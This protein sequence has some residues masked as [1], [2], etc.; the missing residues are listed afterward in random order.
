MQ[1]KKNTFNENAKHTSDNSGDHWCYQDTFE[2]NDHPAPKVEKIEPDYADSDSCASHNFSSHV[3]F[4]LQKDPAVFSTRCRQITSDDNILTNTDKS[5]ELINQ[6]S[7]VL[8]NL[9]TPSDTKLQKDINEK[10][11]H[12]SAHLSTE[13]DLSSN[14]DIRKS[15]NGSNFSSR[16]GTFHYDASSERVHVERKKFNVDSPRLTSHS[17]PGE[18]VSRHFHQRDEREYK[19]Y[20][21]H[22]IERF[23]HSE[24]DASRTHS[25]DHQPHSERWESHNIPRMTHETNISHTLKNSRSGSVS[26]SRTEAGYVENN[27][28]GR[29][30][31]RASS[32]SRSFGLTE[33]YEIPTDHNC[34]PQNKFKCVGEPHYI[35]ET[36]DVELA[37]SLKMQNDEL[38]INAKMP[39]E[40]TVPNS[41]EHHGFK[42]SRLARI[43]KLNSVTERSETRNSVSNADL[44]RNTNS[45]LCW[46]YG[47]GRIKRPLETEEL[48]GAHLPDSKRQIL[49]DITDQE[50][51]NYRD[52][53]KHSE[54]E[55][56]YDTRMKPCLGPV[57]ENTM[58]DYKF[59]RYENDGIRNIYNT[60]LEGSHKAEEMER[61]IWSQNIELN[62]EDARCEDDRKFPTMES[63]VK[64]GTD[65]KL[66]IKSDSPESNER[67]KNVPRRRQTDRQYHE[68]NKYRSN[69]KPFYMERKMS[70]SFRPQYAVKNYY[71]RSRSPFIYNHYSR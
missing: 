35:T 32:H 50:Y 19:A 36:S 7:A 46:E 9:S 51:Y 68:Y 29:Y 65:Y 56:N 53:Y 30:D 34:K 26:W 28:K 14:T 27:S 57:N 40:S 18:P 63:A 45:T 43:L 31:V 44:V 41:S 47:D 67:D 33:A 42:R 6:E 52:N 1:R 59:T 4:P 20:S 8:W 58:K 13:Y 49:D 15:E 54:R 24:S 61:E 71:E 10:V 25:S 12:N 37:S 11:H 64:K 60:V 23:L 17:M 48:D 38:E 55:R 5:H 16:S 3:D 39:H 62:F 66:R 2:Q 70:R 69:R 22:K 21:K